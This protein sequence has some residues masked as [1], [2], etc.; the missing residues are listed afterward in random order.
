VEN[1]RKE[2]G[3]ILNE[4][5]RE[6][7]WMKE[8]WKKRDRVEKER[9]WGYKEKCNFFRTDISLDK[10]ECRNRKTRRANGALSS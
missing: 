8:I 7:G 5:G 10:T 6:I 9:G 4:D 3:E 2:R 1:E